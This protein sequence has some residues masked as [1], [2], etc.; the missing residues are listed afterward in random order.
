MSPITRTEEVLC[1]LLENGDEADR[2]YAARTLGTLRCQGAVDLLITRL[3][4]EDLDV[5]IDAAEALGRIGSTEAVPALIDSLQTEESGEVCTAVT[6]ALGQIADDSALDALLAVATNRPESL[7]WDGDWDTWWDVQLEAVKA[8]GKSGSER[9]VE[10][11]LGLLDDDSQQEIENDILRSLVSITPRG[12]EVVIDRLQNSELP[13]QQ[14]RRAARALGHTDTNMATKVLARALKDSEAEVRAAVAT[15]LADQKAQKYLP[16]LLLMLRDPSEEVRD[17]SIRSCIELSQQ[18]IEQED[19]LEELFALLDDPS[20]Q[21]RTTLFNTL[22][23]TVA[24]QLLTETQRQTVEKSAHDPEGETA[25]A[26]CLLLGNNGDPESIPTL[27]EVVQSRAD[28]PMARRE[29][30]RSLGKFAL[31]NRDIISILA[32]AVGDREQA[33]RMGALSALKELELNGSPVETEDGEMIQRPLSILIGA[34]RGEIDLAPDRKQIIETLQQDAV[35]EQPETESQVV[36]FN[37]EGMPKGSNEEFASPLPNE[38]SDYIKL[39]KDQLQLPETAGEIVQEGDVPSAMSTLDAIAMDNVDA[40]L[41]AAAPKEEPEHDEETQEYLE[42]VEENK[43]TMRRIRSERQITPEQDVRRLA[44]RVLAEIRQDEALDALI[45][46]L[47]DSDDLLRR[48]ATEAI[49]LQAEHNCT[50]PKLMDAVGTLIT[51]L[52]VGDLD[53][54]VACARALGCLGNRAALVPL[55]EAIKDNSSTVRVQAIEALAR[56]CIEGGDPDKAGH[57]VVRDMPPLAVARR[58]LDC[59]DDEQIGVR[60]AAAKG[61]GDVLKHLSEETFTAKTVEKI[62][63]SVTAWTGEEAR[64]MGRVLRTF[65][66]ALGTE[67]LLSHLNQ[68]DNSVKR[69]VFIEMLEE[70]L[71]PDQGQPGQAA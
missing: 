65:D 70:L 26:A 41:N 44:A 3:T 25:T 16:V 48:E 13:A 6:T 50:N 5:S 56:L 24:T 19:V 46:A 55:S 64:Q 71:N 63:S 62:V 33:V 27:L 38:F 61:L 20:G 42:V 67:R 52:T 69:S 68:A 40:V 9:A 66:P 29:A 57:M 34:I 18:G 49:G 8:L 15:A 59:L 60:I 21:V 53:Q 23:R 30:T 45:E 54:K 51:Q 12:V 14:R 47:S 11:L 4:D 39:P 28:H 35:E 31:L 32:K 1:Q 43:E 36:D 58:L 22:A 10:T 37:P 17:S 7:E 2:C